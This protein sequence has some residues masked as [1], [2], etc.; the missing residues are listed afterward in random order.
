MEMTRHAEIIKEDVWET[1]YEGTSAYLSLVAE[2]ENFSKIELKDPRSVVLTINGPRLKG[3]ASILDRLGFFPEKILVNDIN[4]YGNIIGTLISHHRNMSFC[5]H[6]FAFIFFMLIYIVII[7]FIKISRTNMVLEASVEKR[8]Q[9]LNKTNQALLESEMRLKVLHN[10]S[11][12]GI[13]IHKKGMILEC[14][15][16]LSDLMGYSQS[17]LIGM[18]GLLLIAEDSREK[19]M[20]NIASG[21]EKPYEAL[22]LHKNGKAFPM[23][24]EARNIPYKGEMVRSVEFRDLT[25]QKEAEN[26]IKR[27]N[28][29][30]S[31]QLKLINDASGL[32]SNE[33]LQH[34]LDEAERLTNSSIGFYHFL[35]EKKDDIKL[36]LQGWS[37]N[38]IKNGCGLKPNQLHYSV[39]QAGIWC[40]CVEK[41]KTVIHN[42]Y[43]ALENKKGFPEGHVPVVRELVV[44]VFRENKIVAVLGVGNK[45]V[46]YNSADAEAVETLAELSWETIVR[47]KVEEQ[48]KTS[49]E[50]FRLAFLTSPDAI[51]L[52]RLD[53][54]LYLE[55]NKGF[56]E[57]LG[58]TREE[59]I[60]RSSLELNI[61]KNS[62]DR[63]R[64]ISLLKKD[65]IV[66]N[67]E[68]EFLTKSGFVKLG[69]MSART[70][71][72]ENENII[73]SITRDITE[74]RRM[75]LQYQQAQ[76]LDSLGTLAGGIAHDF[77]NILFPILGYSEMLLQDLSDRPDDNFNKKG[78]TAIH[79][80]AVR[81]KELVRQILTFSRQ[82]KDEIKLMKIQPL[83]KE[84][85]KM[86]RA[87]IPASIEIKQ[88][89]A[90]DCGL[91]KAD[92]T[93]VHQ[94]IMN[95]ATNAFHAMEEEG[96]T[97]T[98]EL[99]S[100][101]LDKQNL[102]NPLIGPGS[103]A[104]LSVRDTGDGIS[105][106][107]AEKIF[108]PFFTTKEKGKGTG[109]GLSVV[110]GIV[111]KS[112]GAVALHTEP[113]VGSEFRI[114][115]PLAV[116]GF[117]N[118]RKPAIKQMPM[119]SETILLVDDETTIITMETQML[120][121]LG[122]NVVSR[123]D[124]VEALAL[125]RT[126]PDEFDLI[127]TDL[128]MP[129]MSGDNFARE[130]LKIK[131]DARIVLCTGFGGRLT[132]E[133]IKEIG[134]KG[135][136]HKP[137]VLKELAGKIR[138]ALD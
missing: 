137:I 121:R 2:R 23:R 138:E 101:H 82:Q 85:L 110:H 19:V 100:L 98:V 8:T 62:E 52:N 16:G 112:G 47:K 103:Y 84:T 79:S 135:I 76:K 106:H 45:P 118:A 80:S 67:F 36:S 117:D 48:I 115:W 105:D 17:E 97:L 113:G 122:Y 60:G 126:S 61:W 92:S 93:Q 81:A 132:P 129:K 95:L 29:I 27:K 88:D 26:E 32:T 109:L 22:G 130:V 123:S 69:V 116:V 57:L 74:Q 24:I 72:I 58:Y 9:T 136:L 89:I 54:G 5:V 128:N 21:Y 55:T 6:F 33:L 50:K 120:E 86:L 28:R 78:I 131:P 49:E 73:L 30:Q 12:G 108:E 46:D 114:Y 25:E 66:A 64:L 15:D 3:V 63:K 44:P 107:V 119:G 37:S 7:Q 34:F 91:I 41:G 56:L 59:V 14:N 11:F 71:S 38:T 127:L 43:N 87:T 133:K 68:A 13:A 39:A 125:F 134:M 70:I 51:N 104:F 94:V 65:G 53:D 42:D 1:N 10:A 77:N 111:K 35:K 31:A 4:G 99:K 90:A 75:E 83:L 96:G 18:D 40:E 124:S 102:V 20:D